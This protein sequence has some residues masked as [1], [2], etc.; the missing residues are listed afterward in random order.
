MDHAVVIE[1]L[2]HRY[3]AQQAL[4]NIDLILPAGRTIGLV[5]PD[6]VGKSTLLSLISGIK[7]TQTGRMQ[8]LGGDIKDRAF[9]QSLAPRVAFMPQGLGRN[10]YRSLSVYDNIDFSARLFGVPAAERDER[11]RS[12]MQA[13]GLGPFP[14]RPAGKLSGGMKQKVSLCCA[15]V[16]NPD[17]LVLDEPTTGVDPLSR[18]QFWALVESLRTQRP[19]MTVLVATAY[20]EEAERFEYLVAM[21]EGRVLVCAP[22]IEVLEETR[23]ASLEEAYVKLSCKGDATP[24]LIPPLPPHDGP[25]AMEAEGL[26]RRFGD[27]VAARDVSF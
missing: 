19:Q 16:H 8:V 17:L 23:S 1:G 27:F 25:P 24:L 7:K 3:G 4:D 21:D 5:G 2:S 14:D 12:L 10:L 6:G 18:R 11:I 9:R 26:T 22:T 15:L 20:M 13:T